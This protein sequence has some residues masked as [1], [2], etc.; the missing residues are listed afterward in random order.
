[1]SV[2]HSASEIIAK[3]L[4]PTQRR[5]P[6]TL[7]TEKRKEIA[8]ERQEKTAAIDGEVYKWWETT[9][10]LAVTLAEKYG[11]DA[12]Y[13]LNLMLSGAVK[14]K[15]GRKG[16][17]YNAWLHH[18]S[19]TNNDGVDVVEL[20]QENIEDYYNLTD[21]QKNELVKEFEEEKKSQTHGLRLGARARTKDVSVTCKKIED[22]F[23]GIQG[24]AGVE[25]FYM[26]VR[27]NGDYSFKPRFWFTS[28]SL[29]EYLRGAV[30]R[31]EPEKIGVLA[32]AFA[33]SGANFFSYLKNPKEKVSH[34]KAEIRDMVL[35][36]LREITSNPRVAMSYV[37]F[38]RNIE[39]VYRVTMQGWT[40]S[41]FCNP[42]D[43]SNNIEELQKLRDALAGDQCKFVRLTD[44]Q[45]NAIKQKYE[46]QAAEG[47]LP[48]RQKRSDAGMK[49]KK[50]PKATADSESR[51]GGEEGG[52]GSSAT[53]SKRPR[54][55]GKDD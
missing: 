50:A 49:R 1:M 2:V 28:E 12:N 32:E 14:L 43:L 26:I 52:E 44:S 27:S 37:H 8:K 53:L 41:R 46:A 15:G 21:E 39:L 45:Y 23:T 54:V 9:Q 16:N 29:D 42:S 48:E 38:T 18:L 55:E 25:G 24:R 34:L 5:K 11:R 6:P 19:Q 33:I 3:P 40:A 7:T 35:E 36:A 22:L 47:L 17:A 30:R 51:A 10:G 20:G 4:E 31:F 13:Y